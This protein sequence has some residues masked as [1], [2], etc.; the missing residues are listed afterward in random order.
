[1]LSGED[2]KLLQAVERALK[3]LPQHL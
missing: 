2:E 3:N 1:V